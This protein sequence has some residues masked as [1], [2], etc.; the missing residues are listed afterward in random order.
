M[1]FSSDF[2][3]LEEPGNMV[4]GILMRVHILKRNQRIKLMITYLFLKVFLK[5]LTHLF[6]FE[7]DV[8]LITL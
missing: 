1:K 8:F 6:L 5:N 4:N 2:T 3:A 7:D